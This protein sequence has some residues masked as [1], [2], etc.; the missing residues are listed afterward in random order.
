MTELDYELE[1]I[2]AMKP[3]HTH[4]LNNKENVAFWHAVEKLGAQAYE[5]LEIG[6]IK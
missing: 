2:E 1:I 3:I 6:K 5:V 4:A